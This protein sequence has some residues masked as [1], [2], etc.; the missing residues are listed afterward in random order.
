MLRFYSSSNGI[1][2]S[3][4]AV[5]S[6]INES[7]LHM[8]LSSCCLIVVHSTI[9]HNFQDILEKAKELCPSA[10]IVGCTCAGIIGREGPKE[11]IR[12]LAIMMVYADRDDLVHIVSRPNISGL[13]SFEVA[14]EM[15]QELHQ[16]NQKINMLQIFGSGIDV[17]ADQ[18]IGGMESVFGKE[19]PIFGGTSSDN[20]KAITSYQFYEDGVL[21]KGIVMIGYADPTLSVEM[22]VHHGSDPVGIGFKVTKSAKNKVEEIEEVPA[23]HYIM[24]ALGLPHDTH[25]G[26]CIPTAGL[27]ELLTEDLHDEYD[28]QHILRVVTKVDKDGSFYM[29]VFCPKG[30]RLWLTKR[31]EGLIFNGLDRMLGKLKNRLKGKEIVAV[32]HTDCAARGRAM[33]DEINKEEIIGK[34]QKV[35]CGDRE[36]PW[37][38]MYGY[39]EFT[40]LGGRN[41]FHNYTTSL[42]VLTR[43]EV[44]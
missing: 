5:E 9:G 25:P 22:A 15:A 24:D 21:E 11:G 7:A 8:E 12:S 36:K 44:Q 29:P 13:N 39:G 43:K 3:S 10:I 38:G 6:C 19:T 35:I 18:I 16:M 26:P 30:T 34:M 2:N 40:L 4:K 1:V 37:L 27:G 33:F 28:N 23:W 42:Y 17:A 32:F 14:S 41:R 20:M 31:N